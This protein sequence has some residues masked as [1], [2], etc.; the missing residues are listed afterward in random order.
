MLCCVAGATINFT[1]VPVI[2]FTVEADHPFFF[3]IVDDVNS[4]PLFSG[5]VVAP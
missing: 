4:L 3:F 1:S 5:W 2:D